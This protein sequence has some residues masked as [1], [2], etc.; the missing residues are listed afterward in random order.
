V[1][2]AVPV[3]LAVLVTVGLIGTTVRP[4]PE[5]VPGPHVLE[6]F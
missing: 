4:E 6:M 3:A 1:C 5:M 2:V